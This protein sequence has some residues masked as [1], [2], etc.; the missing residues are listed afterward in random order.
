MFKPLLVKLI[1]YFMQNKMH[2]S[3]FD[4][5]TK[6][7]RNLPYADS[8]KQGYKDEKLAGLSVINFC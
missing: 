8:E 7:E 1:S 4:R 5:F 2:K 3:R 6:H